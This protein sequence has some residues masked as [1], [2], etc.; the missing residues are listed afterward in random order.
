[1]YK[2]LKAA[3]IRKT[4]VQSVAQTIGSV[5]PENRSAPHRPRKPAIP[6]PETPYILK[7]VRVNQADFINQLFHH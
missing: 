3:V 5:H 2:L 7:K 6:R 1:M 4:T